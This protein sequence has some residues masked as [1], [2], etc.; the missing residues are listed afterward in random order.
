MEPLDPRKRARKR[1]A[2]PSTADQ[3][4]AGI[5]EFSQIALWMTANLAG[6]MTAFFLS[7]S[8]FFE[9]LAAKIIGRKRSASRSARPSPDEALP[10][11]ASA[12]LGSDKATIESVF[13]PPRA[14]ALCGAGGKAAVLAPDAIFWHADTWYYPLPRNGPLAMAIGFDAQLAKRVEFFQTPRLSQCD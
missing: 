9:S 11:L 4:S 7:R 6:L 12:I 1:P 5:N 8:S 3:L 10:M 14:A 2:E 13:G